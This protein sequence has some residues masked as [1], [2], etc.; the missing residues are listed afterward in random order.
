MSVLRPGNHAAASLTSITALDQF[1]FV[2]TLSYGRE[3]HLRWTWDPAK[4]E[5]NLKKHKVSFELA[6][7][8]FGDPF[9]IT[10]PDPCP[11][12][13]RWRTIGKRS[14]AGGKFAPNLPHAR[15]RTCLRKAVLDPIVC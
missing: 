11:D 13:E 9:S 2:Y 14:T 3:G 6:V 8:V 15:E 4:A 12:E 1:R 7:R 10:V 5:A